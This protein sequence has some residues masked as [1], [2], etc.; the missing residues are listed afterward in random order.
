MRYLPSIFTLRLAVCAMIFFCSACR[1]CSSEKSP[2][3]QTASSTNDVKYDSTSD[4]VPTHIVA[5]SNT[6]KSVLPQ[7]VIIILDISKSISNAS[8]EKAKYTLLDI[9]D[10]MKNKSQLLVFSTTK[11][12]SQAPL[13]NREKKLPINSLQ[14]TTYIRKWKE[15]LKKKVNNIQSTFSKKEEVT[16]LIFAMKSVKYYLR[17]LPPAKN[18]YLLFI[19]DMLECC[20][21]LCIENKSSIPGSQNQ[22]KALNLTYYQLSELIPLTNIEAYLL[23]E[24]L[25]RTHLE[26]IDSEEFRQFWNQVFAKFGYDNAPNFT[27]SNSGFINKL[28]S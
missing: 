18:T 27:T 3:T 21:K 1:E 25:L 16:C 26:S 8:F 13:I 28:N 23:T 17:G 15:E 10:K 11:N 9:A 7:R 20:E 14:R 4:G 12:P 24:N 22:L 19:S 6:A 2:E 5:A